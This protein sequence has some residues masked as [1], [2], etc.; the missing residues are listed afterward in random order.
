MNDSAGHHAGDE[1]LSAIAAR[2]GAAVRPNDVVARFGG[3]EFVVLADGI[4]DTRDA[5]Q[6]AWRL[7][8]ALRAP[9][10]VSGAELSVSASFGV[11][12]SRDRDE[13][14]EDLVRKADAA[15]YTAKQRGR[16]RVA[17]FGETAS[18]DAVIGA[19]GS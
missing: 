1:L 8:S 15:M 10:A 11:C 17:V 6:L 5:V 19:S 16:N 9:F 18:A 3:D 7:A 13:S 14:P 4:G 12:Y 2:L